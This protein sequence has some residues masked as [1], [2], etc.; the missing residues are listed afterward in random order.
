MLGFL[1]MLFWFFNKTQISK[2]KLEEV[3]ATRD[4]G[5]DCKK[6]CWPKALYLIEVSSDGLL[7]I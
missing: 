3:K 5:S 2:W 7:Q 6:G 4:N 1:E